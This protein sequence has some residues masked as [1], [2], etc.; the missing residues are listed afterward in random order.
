ML[1]KKNAFVVK[2]NSTRRGI[3]ETTKKIHLASCHVLAELHSSF[4]LDATVCDYL[5]L[6]SMSKYKEFD[7]QVC[8]TAFNK[9]AKRGW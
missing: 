2:P 9:L 5:F 1:Y 4:G 8:G 3:S 6:E 7:A